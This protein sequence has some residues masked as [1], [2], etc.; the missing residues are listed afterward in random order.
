[1][2][3]PLPENAPAHQAPSEAQSWPL[4]VRVTG[5]L[6]RGSRPTAGVQTWRGIPYAAPPVGPLRFCAPQR[7]I[8]WTGVRD[9]TR[10]GPVAPQ[11]RGTQFKGVSRRTRMG[12]DCL[13]LNVQRPADQPDE[14]N[15]PVMV[16]IHGGGYTAG[17]S[18]DFTER[19]QDIVRSGG[20]VYV[21]LNYRLGA[22]GYLDF[23]R[24]STRD[25][26]FESNLGLRDQVAALEWVQGNIRSFGG[27]P[28]NVT[29]I[30]ESA[31]G[32]A[33]VTLL[34]TPTARG[35]F[36]R[37]I[38]QSPPSNA[39][40]SP[41][42]AGRWA[43]E[44]IEVLRQGRAPELAGGRR[45]AAELLDTAT[46]PALVRAALVL[47][48]RTPDVDPGTFCMAPVVDGNF[49]PERPLDAF[50]Q[51]HAHPVPLIIGTNDREG[52]MFRGRL[53]ILPRSIQR[54]QSLFDEAPPGSH[55]GM[56]AVYS[57]LP[58]LRAEA[59]FSGDYAF[60][61]PSVQV[62][63]LHSRS[64]PVYLYRFDLAPRLLHLLGYDAT[65][66]LELLALSTS[67]ADGQLRKLTALGG[68]ASFLRTGDRMR[69]HWLR[70][71]ATGLTGPGWPV[72]TE[73]DRLTL[74]FDEEDRVES[75]PR[76]ERRVAWLQFLPDL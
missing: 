49:L 67:G 69:A 32:N 73:G 29:V 45:P 28:G 60:W 54:I 61:F 1:M 13:T 7:V 55:Q 2:F 20:A 14:A 63:D 39:A 3:R 66:G 74:I 36:A 33:V 76:G 18:Q 25:R 56:R 31:G 72:Y 9:A 53:D 65:H 11:D 59:D 5:G 48:R 51:G 71:A 75:D 34:A 70:F 43:S 12:E 52:S 47:Q 15:M 23:S 68:R 27:D 46:W 22:L 17:C 64:A 21:A 62:A 50:R 40:Y 8:P 4:E 30:G 6:V 57:A 24:F 41:A 26:T 37:A 58:A 10:Y 19:S 35:L 16:F 38:A 42:L 44:F